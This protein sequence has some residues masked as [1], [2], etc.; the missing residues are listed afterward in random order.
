VGFLDTSPGAFPPRHDA[1]YLPAEAFEALRSILSGS[2]AYL[3]LCF[4]PAL[5]KNRIKGQSFPASKIALPAPTPALKG[6]RSILT[7][8]VVGPQGRE[9]PFLEDYRFIE[10]QV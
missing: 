4:V 10:G 1:G 9:N 6:N 7:V 3:A 5:E 2:P 8:I